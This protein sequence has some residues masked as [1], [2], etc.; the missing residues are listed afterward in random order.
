MKGSRLRFKG[1]ENIGSRLKAIFDMENGFS[2]VTGK[3]GQ[4][5]AIFGRQAL[6]GLSTGEFGS[7]SSVVN[8]TFPFTHLK[9]TARL[10]GLLVNMQTIYSITIG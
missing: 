8:M 4:G 1:A 5:E 7:V 10:R 2:L 9:T 3:F 6:V